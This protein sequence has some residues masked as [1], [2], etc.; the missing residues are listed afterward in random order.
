M[1]LYRRAAS[2]RCSCHHVQEG[3]ETLCL[4]NPCDCHLSN[5]DQ[6]CK[7]GLCHKPCA[8]SCFIASN[9]LRFMHDCGMAWRRTCSTLKQPCHGQ[10]KC[11]TKLATNSSSQRQRHMKG[12]KQ[13]GRAIEVSPTVAL[14][15]LATPYVMFATVDRVAEIEKASSAAALTTIQKS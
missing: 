14:L 8:C 10:C 6:A 2:L 4:V 5:L 11:A 3:T 7:S 12:R 9:H 1:N 13:A 15:M